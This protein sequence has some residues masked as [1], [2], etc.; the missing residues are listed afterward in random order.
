MTY[1]LLLAAERRAEQG[2][3]AAWRVPHFM[4]ARSE[5]DS[6]SNE[7]LLEVRCSAAS[8]IATKASYFLGLHAFAVSASMSA[9]FHKR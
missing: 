1:C 8:S 4:A 2:L 6:T 5:L 7:T 3:T 9:Q